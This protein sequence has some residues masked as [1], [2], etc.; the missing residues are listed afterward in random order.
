MLKPDLWIRIEIERNRIHFKFKKKPD[1]DP[2]FKEFDPDPTRKNFK[3][4]S[5]LKKN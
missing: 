2:I 1:T 3:S 5:D 4:D